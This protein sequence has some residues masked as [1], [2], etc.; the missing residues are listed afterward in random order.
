M[1]ISICF[2]RLYC[3]D[4]AFLR[5]S[6]ETFNVNPLSAADVCIRQILK[7]PKR[8]QSMSFIFIVVLKT[9]KRL[10]PKDLAAVQGL[11]LVVALNN[12]HCFQSTCA[13]ENS[14]NRR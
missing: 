2:S 5:Q 12:H 11:K 13:Q 7:F 14:Y 3:S 4:A 1:D 10:T 8:F 9:R 6:T